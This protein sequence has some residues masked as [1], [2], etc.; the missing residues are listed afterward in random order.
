MVSRSGLEA[1]FI[2]RELILRKEIRGRKEAQGKKNKDEDQA[3]K[4]VKY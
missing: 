1:T 3:K 2:G 4:E